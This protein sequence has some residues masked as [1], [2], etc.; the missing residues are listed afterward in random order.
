MQDY[1][2]SYNPSCLIEYELGWAETRPPICQENVNHQ[3]TLVLGH[4]I[5]PSIHSSVTLGNLRPS[6]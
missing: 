1:I 5:H 3:R 6:I 2:T 4:G